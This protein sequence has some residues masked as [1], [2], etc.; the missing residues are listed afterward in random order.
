MVQEDLMNKVAEAIY[1][2]VRTFSDGQLEK[3]LTADILA[4]HE[5]MVRENGA[6]A[7]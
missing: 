3:L 4:A 2:T 5:R 6:V 1:S 7:A